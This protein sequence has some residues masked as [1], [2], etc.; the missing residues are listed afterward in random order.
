MAVDKAL[1]KPNK[2]VTDFF[3]SQPNPQPSSSQSSIPS[4]FSRVK[5][6]PRTSPSV[7]LTQGGSSMPKKLTKRAPA[8]ATVSSARKKTASARRP[9]SPAGTIIS[10]SSGGASDAVFSLSDS[11]ANNSIVDL[12]GPSPIQV[13]K[14]KGVVDLTFSSSSDDLGPA[15]P[16]SPLDVSRTGLDN[17]GT[18]IPMP[19][20]KSITPAA[21]IPS[22]LTTPPTSPEQADRASRAR[23][24]TR[25]ARQSAPLTAAAVRTLPSAS[26]PIPPSASQ[27][28]L[29][30]Q[31][32]HGPS[33]APSG[34]TTRA[35]LSPTRF[36]L[37]S[38]TPFASQSRPAPRTPRSPVRVKRM[39]VYSSSDEDSA[40]SEE[41]RDLI[42]ADPPPNVIPK[43][44]S[45]VKPTSA[46]STA[47][48]SLS[49]ASTISRTLSRPSK[50]AR[51]TPMTDPR[52]PL[53]QPPSS[54]PSHH[55]SP[56]KA[57]VHRRAA[58]GADEVLPSSQRAEDGLELA[59]SSPSK[60]QEAKV[61]QAKDDT[62]DGGWN[63][64]GATGDWDMDTA[65][66][67]SAGDG[68]AGA[69]LQ[70]I[71]EAHTSPPSQSRRPSTCDALSLDEVEVSL[72]LPA[73]DSSPAPTAP[74][75]AIP[76]PSSPEQLEL[77]K[78]Q[79]RDERTKQIIAEI[80]AKAMMEIE[81]ELEEEEA[82]LDLEADSDELE[83][84]NDVWTAAMADKTR[85]KM[86][87]SA[88]AP[89]RAEGSPSSPLSTPP[90]SPSPPRRTR[91]NAHL[92]SPTPA[93]KRARLSP[94]ATLP[95]K[96]SAK[97]NRDLNR[98]LKQA[99]KLERQGITAAIQKAEEI[100]NRRSA[101]P[102]RGRKRTYSQSSGGSQEMDSVEGSSV[103]GAAVL[104]HLGEHKDEMI[105][106]FERDKAERREQ[107][108]REEH[109]GK[110]SRVFWNRTAASG[111][112][113]IEE[114]W[115][116]GA[117]KDDDLM[118][119]VVNAVRNGDTQE[120]TSILYWLPFP[121]EHDAELLV[122]WLFRIATR[123]SEPGI[124]HAAYSHLLHL[125]STS[126][127]CRVPF[128]NVMSA[129]RDIGVIDT[130]LASCD[131]HNAALERKSL[132]W[133]RERAWIFA[134]IVCA[135]VRGRMFNGAEMLDSFVLLLLVAMDPVT[136]P[137]LKREI[138]FALEDAA[139]DDAVDQATGLAIC[140]RISTLIAEWSM[141]QKAFLLSLF[142]RGQDNTMIMTRWLAVDV[143]VGG[144]IDM[145]DVD[146][147]QDPPSLSSLLDLID[148][149]S[150][151]SPFG[152]HVETDYE[153]LH[154]ATQIM[155]I[156]LT[157]V[158]SYLGVRENHAKLQALS[159]DIFTVYSKISELTRLIFE[160]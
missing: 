130:A 151:S 125:V 159:E 117:W 140:K 61:G 99:E 101:S 17:L 126:P 3:S 97:S 10:V 103:S 68:W 104:E 120:L 4:I 92:A 116:V 138:T 44:P 29:R 19:L 84:L 121:G 60:S 82:A 35:T 76:T 79:L 66:P 122:L 64:G 54:T 106:L 12:C 16:S 91:A 93:G 80:K 155:E 46:Q 18:H 88:S 55:N 90:T 157:N 39:R 62:W 160:F 73:L 81:E 107:Q 110:G 144:T 135:F 132:A 25:Q 36:R 52:S 33:N 27:R 71:K 41:M 2:K 108:F 114:D 148:Y 59:F 30:A 74:S 58:G 98:L 15:E 43:L 118:C 143:L 124:A 111:K 128:K 38:Q 127:Q 149:Q 53:T 72:A 78:E 119:S 150:R 134:S 87:E 24:T 20:A 158:H 89:S 31:T 22:P 40:P 23:S 105:K 146:S 154:L 47:S 26:P 95:K 77:T 9:S 67:D 57:A 63:D 13:P 6:E 8:L 85:A 42:V 51:T 83:D 133:S 123:H 48:A 112:S 136:S 45:P 145:L 153:R 34:S 70:S 75:S 56:F 96:E 28:T 109:G 100:V 152:V 113:R 11:S 14:N 37:K 156:A 7:P 139:N 137:E 115:T 32:P 102:I 94:P 131:A 147:Y 86:T 142:P 1:T 49:P 69:P 50:R 141:A 5:P 21:E 65:A 129:C